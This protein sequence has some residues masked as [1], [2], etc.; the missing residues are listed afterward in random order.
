MSSLSDK[1]KS[2][3]DY[4]AE[5]VKTVVTNVYLS[6]R[7]KV[8]LPCAFVMLA[9]HAIEQTAFNTV[10]H[11]C[12]VTVTILHEAADVETGYKELID[13]LCSVRDA[14]QQ[15][16]TLGGLVLDSLVTRLTIPRRQF[17][18]HIGVLTLECWWRE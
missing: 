16:R 12:A 3:L 4:V 9:E 11:T 2:I 1:L 18:R 6:E 10:R 7:E 5:R 13:K 15:D 14:L 8:R 17:M